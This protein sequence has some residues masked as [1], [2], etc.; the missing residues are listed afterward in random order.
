MSIGNASGPVVTNLIFLVK[1]MKL[2][3][4]AFNYLS[5]ASILYICNLLV[6]PVT[7]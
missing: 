4:P 6:R 7:R 3:E 1:S 2:V 5:F